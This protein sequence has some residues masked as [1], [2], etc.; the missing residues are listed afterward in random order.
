MTH[1]I[2]KKLVAKYIYAAMVAWIPL[3]NH[4]E[5]D[6]IGRPLHTA[7]GYYKQED[8]TEVRARYES[9]ASDI[10]DVAYD[11]TLKPMFTG[12]DGRLKSALTL[13]GTGSM[14]GVYQ[15]WV[16]NGDCNTAAFQAREHEV[17]PGH[18]ACDGGAA[19]S[20][21]QIHMYRYIIKDGELTQA[22]ILENSPNPADREWIK[23]HK[24]EI[25]TG[26]QLVA[27]RKLAARIA[28][29][30]MY[31]SLHTYHSLCTYSG[32]SCSGA[33]PLADNRLSRG[34]Q[35]LRAH[36]FTTPPP[37]ELALIASPADPSRE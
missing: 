25:I 30:L 37:E 32:E 7:Q 2:L 14:E 22:G 27:D 16:E 17:H 18:E 36:L 23:N 9:I 20:I 33:H 28:Y 8:Q 10:V 12:E 15:K 3:S 35:Y 21:F 11:D 26:A 34:Q 5:R 19:W 29:Y 31:N 1:I 6:A 13:A 24:N 4:Y